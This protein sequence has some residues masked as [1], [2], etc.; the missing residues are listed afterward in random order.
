[1]E[2][3]TV[4]RAAVNQVGIAC[5]SATFVND[6]HVE[7]PNALHMSRSVLGADRIPCSMVRSAGTNTIAEPMTAVP[8]DPRPKTSTRI[9]AT[10]TM[11]MACSAVIVGTNICSMVPEK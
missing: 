6:V 7:P 2:V 4:M 8:T 9:G 10:V 1:M 3:V 5:G 11:G